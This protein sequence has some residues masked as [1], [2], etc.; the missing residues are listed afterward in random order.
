ML[1]RTLAV[2]LQFI[3]KLIYISKY[4]RSFF[5]PLVQRAHILQITCSKETIYGAITLVRVLVYLLDYPFYFRRSS[6]SLYIFVY[7][8]VIS[9]YSTSS[10]HKSSW[11]SP[12]I[13]KDWLKFKLLAFIV[14]QER[15]HLGQL[16]IK[17]ETV[18]TEATFCAWW[19]LF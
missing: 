4:S 13:F 8:F 14:C 19:A 15:I 3:S 10:I 17:T 11:P 5:S 18:K 1:R 6:C 9:V 16:Q 2:Y 12:C 7:P